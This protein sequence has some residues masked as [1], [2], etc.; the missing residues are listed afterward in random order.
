MLQLLIILTSISII[1]L[2]MMLISFL[3]SKKMSMN[4]EKISPFE[5]GF[6][7]ATPSRL[8]LSIQFFL[9]SMIFLIFDIEIALLIPMILMTHSF[10]PSL[11]YTSLFFLLILMF[12]LYTEYLE[13]SIDWKI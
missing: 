7:P 12:G 9:I 11:M 1:P 10:S 5:C 4:R 8:P 3:I 13:Q 2:I 6:D